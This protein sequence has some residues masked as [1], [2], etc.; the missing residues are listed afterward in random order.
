MYKLTSHS[1]LELFFYKTIQKDYFGK[2]LLSKC[3]DKKGSSVSF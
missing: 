3:V 2:A 1:T